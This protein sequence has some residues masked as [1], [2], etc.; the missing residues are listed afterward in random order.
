M[1]LARTEQG[2]SPT[3]RQIVAHLDRF[4]VGQQT[5]KRALA[6]AAHAHLRRAEL[7]RRGHGRPWKKANVLLIGPT[8]TGKTMLGRHL[9]ECLG[10]PF[11]VADA[12]E[13]T[14]AGYY[15]KDVEL[16]LTDLLARAGHSSEEAQ[17]GIVFIDE[18]DKIARRTQGPQSGT[19]ARD[20]GG[21]GVQ[22]ALLKLLE[23][24]EIQVPLAS[25]HPWS[26]PEAVT[27]DTT[28]VLFIC[29]GTFSELTNDRRDLRTIGF[30]TSGAMPDT[31]TVTPSELVRY[32]MLAE[33][34]GR[35]PVIAPVDALDLDAL[36]RIL[37]EPEDALVNEFR[38]RLA[39]DG[40]EL[41]VRPSAL[42]AL[43]R[44]AQARSVGAR[45]LRALMELA[46]EQIL[47]DAPERAGQRV[48]LDGDAVRR[49]LG[50]R[51]C[52]TDRNGDGPPPEG[53]RPVRRTRRKAVVD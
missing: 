27:L 49:S 15:G 47:F 41:V 11:S 8:G 37:V 29:A 40:V 3:P 19:G 1:K 36:K 42:D 30:G 14:E 12:T 13:Y 52:A 43:A 9:A 26:R 32:G 4:V 44:A 34:V 6:V 39:W 38:E 46:C 5:A 2:L 53:R 17:R 7:M 33:F 10:V 31:E 22:Q 45:G 25:A 18:V 51:P 20:I 35:L 24:R 28:S 23:G 21:E 50:E 48:V 16:M